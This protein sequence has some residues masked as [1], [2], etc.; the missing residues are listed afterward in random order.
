MFEELLD[1]L[2]ILIPTNL[3][4]LLWII[5]RTTWFVVRLTF[6]IHLKTPTYRKSGILR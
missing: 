4:Q 5:P 3:P 6:S 2:P 1:R